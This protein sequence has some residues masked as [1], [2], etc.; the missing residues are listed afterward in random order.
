MPQLCLPLSA[1]TV[2]PA[3]SASLAAA[4]TRPAA[5]H[6]GVPSEQRDVGCGGDGGAEGKQCGLDPIERVCRSGSCVACGDSGL[7][8]CEGGICDPATSV[9][10][11]FRFDT[12]ACNANGL[13]AEDCGSRGLRCCTELDADDRAEYYYDTDSPPKPVTDGCDRFTRCS[14]GFCRD[15]GH[16]GE[17]CCKH[18][19]EQPSG[20]GPL[21]PLDAQL[22]YDDCNTS[23]SECEEETGMCSAQTCGSLGLPCCENSNLECTLLVT[24]VHLST[25]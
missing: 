16:P 11:L 7:P 21:P 14:S 9:T 3:V 23:S 20:H 22:V 25:V 6:A 4:L 24:V 15:C 19:Q 13:C 8:C 1:L 5:V 18:F 17:P 12:L 2:V 10:L